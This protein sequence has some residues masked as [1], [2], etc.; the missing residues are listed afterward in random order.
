MIP[1]FIPFKICFL[2]FLLLSTI[3]FSE[4]L[5]AHC[6]LR[7]SRKTNCGTG[8]GG[9]PDLQSSPGPL[10]FRDHEVSWRKQKTS[11]S[12]IRHGPSYSR[13]WI[14]FLWKWFTYTAGKGWLVICGRSGGLQRKACL[15][16]LCQLLSDRKGDTT[17]N[18]RK[19]WLS[20]ISVSQIRKTIFLRGLLIM[21]P[22]LFFAK[23]QVTWK[24]RILFIH[25]LNHY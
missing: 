12:I 15:V 20:H 23:A 24:N 7:N 17:R 19:A 1:T 6:V 16:T 13:V 22:W 21:Q 3:F 9:G 18:T 10:N 14:S 8:N 4:D 11:P 5:V 2:L 25:S